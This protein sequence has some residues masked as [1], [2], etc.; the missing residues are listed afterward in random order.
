MKYEVGTHWLTKGGWRAAI[1]E[2]N[3]NEL[4]VWHY[5][6]LIPLIHG[7]DG[8]AKNDDYSLTEPC[9]YLPFGKFHLNIY[10][11]G[12]PIAFKKRSH[13][14]EY[15]NRSAQNRRIACIEAHWTEGEG[16]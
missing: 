6:K 1:V 12:N 2:S 9:E 14:D 4:S 7:T 5:N 11:R 13:A 16:L 10:K 3:D 15:E 8:T